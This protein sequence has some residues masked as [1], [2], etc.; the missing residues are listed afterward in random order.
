[1]V[2]GPLVTSPSAGG[3]RLAYAPGAFDQRAPSG[4]VAH[5]RQFV[6]HARALGHQVWTWPDR[7][8]PD[9]RPLPVSRLARLNAL[10]RMDAVYVRCG[11][12]PPVPPHRALAAVRRL[13]GRP[14]MVWEFNAPPEFALLQGGTEASV[15]RAVEAFRRLGRDCDLAIC[16]SD[17]L[18]RYVRDGLGLINVLT[19]P[20]GSDPELFRPDATPV[21]RVERA[22]NRLNVAWIGSLHIPWH[23]VDLFREAAGLLWKR[24]DGGRVAFHLIG[25]GP[26]GLMRDMPPNVHFHGP[27]EYTMVPRWLAAMD[28]GLCLYKPGPAA[29]SSP[30]KLFDYMASGL[31]VVGTRQPQLE[32][33][34][35]E[36]G[37]SDLVIP[38]A[39]PAALAHALLQLADDRARVR[40][41]G[42]A[43]RQ[44]AIAFYNWRRVVRDTMNGIEA[45]VT[46]RRHSTPVSR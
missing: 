8:L 7:L 11:S 5:V 9:T 40:R 20:N 41:Q 27:Q 29:Y 2:S 35:A 44:Q 6:A 43:G 10:R 37:Q 15:T 18:T 13:T 23:D 25:A 28:V 12:A 32:H 4:K 33:V 31:T 19:V 21:D 34:F 42:L 14:L 3:L 39:D 46:G 1:M 17:N 45:L 26:P 24:G 16:V 22:A 30:L 36:L 38:P